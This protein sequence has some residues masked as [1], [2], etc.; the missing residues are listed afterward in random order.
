MK[1]F[2]NWAI[3][4]PGNIAEKMGEAMFVTSQKNSSIKCYAVASRN[5][6]KA[7]KFCNKW[8][9]KKAYGNYDELYCDKNVDAVYIAS[10]H[11]F[12]YEMIKNC[13]KNGKHVLCEKPATVNSAMLN[14][15]IALAVEK[16][17]FF[18]EALWTAFNPTFNKVL[19]TI[20]NGVIGN[21]LNVRSFFLQQK[22]I[23]F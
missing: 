4:A 20:Q 2:V 5:L 11:A 21:V 10:P 1:D 19:E 7:K 8:N 3:V 18:M 6:E 22:R 23:R 16:K 14:E 13:L 9:F 12:H 15:V 17:L